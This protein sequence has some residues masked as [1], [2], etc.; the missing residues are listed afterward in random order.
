MGPMGCAMQE[1][2]AP[3]KSGPGRDGMECPGVC[4]VKCGPNET[5]CDGGFD[6]NNCKMADRC[7]PFAQKTVNQ[8]ELCALV[9]KMTMIVWFRTFVFPKM[10]PMDVLP[11]KC[12]NNS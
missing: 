10:I 12:E 6:P 8:M 1:V 5:F 3:G 11:L 7:I 4:P 2:C 9:E